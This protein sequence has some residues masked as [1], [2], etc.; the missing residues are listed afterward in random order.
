[1]TQ[2]HPDAYARFARQHGLE[3][4]IDELYSAPR[5][6]SAPPSELDR[7][8]L[9][10]LNSAHADRQ[11][12]L[13]LFVLPPDFEGRPSIRDVLWWLASDAWAIEQAGSSRERWTTM[14]QYPVDGQAAANLFLLHQRQSIALAALLGADA[15]KAL[16]EIHQAQVRGPTDHVEPLGR[17]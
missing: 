12:I 16:L 13:A 2:A 3:I 4:H 10:T 8:M 14:H 7:H 1:M 11:P 9:V 6:V 15:Y 5:D 17:F